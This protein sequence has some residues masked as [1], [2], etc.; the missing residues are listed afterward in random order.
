MK[1][2]ARNPLTLTAAR[3]TLA[4][5][6]L[7]LAVS[8]ALATPQISPQSI[9]VNPVQAS[10]SVKVS[11]DRGGSNPVYNIGD[12]IRVNVN[13]SDDAYVYLFSVHAD[14][15]IDQILPNR[16]SGGSQFLRAGETRSFPPS[17]AQYQLNVDGPSGQDKV[18]AVASKRQLDTSDIASF[19]GNQPFATSSIQ[20]QDNLARALSIVVT[21]VPS[22]D[23]ITDVAYFQ[24]Q[25]RYTTTAPAPAPRN[26]TGNTTTI[27]VQ[28]GLNAYPGSV[29]VRFDDPSDQAVNVQLSSGANLNTVVQ[30]YNTELERNGWQMVAR[31]G[32]GSTVRLMFRRSNA[33][34]EL[35]IRRIRGGFQLNLYQR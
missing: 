33:T 20:G 12:S 1:Q 34:I 16:L 24:V 13:V 3:I 7:A 14:G 2:L 8:T 28:Y 21:P 17:G 26:T 32:N 27:S 35:E 30:F 19:K 25:P 5:G 18:L 6:T 4:M 29:I 31:A 23:W 11:V 22:S 9:I 15:Q 10:L